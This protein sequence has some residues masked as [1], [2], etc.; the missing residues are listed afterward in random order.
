MTSDL[1]AGQVAARLAQHGLA[2]FSMRTPRDVRRATAKVYYLGAR[3]V[4]PSL[5]VGHARRF[6]TSDVDA[7]AAGRQA[8]V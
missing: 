6:L 1:T 3:G 5:K 7:F 2:G 4:L 8:G